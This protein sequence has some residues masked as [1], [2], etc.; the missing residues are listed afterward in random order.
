[1]FSSFGLDAAAWASGFLSSDPSYQLSRAV[2]DP[3]VKPPIDFFE[4]LKIY[5][6]LLPPKVSIYLNDLI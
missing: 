1:M 5:D 4:K 3:P 2:V 6:Q